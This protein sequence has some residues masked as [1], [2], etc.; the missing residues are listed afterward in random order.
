METKLLL[1]NRRTKWGAWN[2]NEFF[3]YFDTII[4]FNEKSQFH[5][6]YGSFIMKIFVSCQRSLSQCS[7]LSEAEALNEVADKIIKHF[8]NDFGRKIPAIHPD[9]I[10][11]VKTENEL[12]GIFLS[13]FFAVVILWLI[14]YRSQEKF[15]LLFI[16]FDVGCKFVSLTLFFASNSIRIHE[17]YFN[18]NIFLLLLLLWL[19]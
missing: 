6:L 15:V 16:V 19:F 2:F 3:T 5:L 10:M 7:A 11:C 4:N 17:F 1:L 18:M 14:F 9:R 12:Y 8:F 13:V